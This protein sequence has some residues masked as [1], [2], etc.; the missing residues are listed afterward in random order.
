MDSDIQFRLQV[1]DPG[2]LKKSKLNDNE[3]CE[4]E[5]NLETDDSMEITSNMLK[6]G[7]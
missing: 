5:F 3:A 1:T 7:I 4:F 6:K 2:K